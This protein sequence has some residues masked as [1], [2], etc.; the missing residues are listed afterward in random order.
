MRTTNWPDLR[1]TDPISAAEHLAA[2]QSDF[3][4]LRA[5]SSSTGRDRKVPSDL[6][7]RIY[8]SYTALNQKLVGVIS[9]QPGPQTEAGVTLTNEDTPQDVSESTALHN[10]NKPKSLTERYARPCRQTPQENIDIPLTPRSHTF[11]ITIDD[12]AVATRIDAMDN[13]QKRLLICQAT[14]RDPDEVARHSGKPWI[15]A[16]RLESGKTLRIYCHTL[17]ERSLLEMTE[18]TTQILESTLYAQVVTFGVLMEDVWIDR[19]DLR[20]GVRNHMAAQMLAIA[21]ASALPSLFKH[22]DLMSVQK[23]HSRRR[24]PANL[25]IEFATPEVANE[26]ISRGLKWGEKKHKC[27]RLVRESE[28]QKCK[29]CQRFGH[30]L[31]ECTNGVACELCLRPHPTENCIRQQCSFCR[32]LHTPG[33]LCKFHG[34]EMSKA[35]EEVRSRQPLWPVTQRSDTDVAPRPAPHR[36]LAET[37]SAPASLPRA[38]P[39]DSVQIG[40]QAKPRRNSAY[41]SNNSRVSVDDS[42]RDGLDSG[43]SAVHRELDPSSSSPVPLQ[44]QALAPALTQCKKRR[45]TR[46][47]HISNA[48]EPHSHGKRVKYTRNSTPSTTIEELEDPKETYIRESGS[49]TAEAAKDLKNALERAGIVDELPHRAQPWRRRRRSPVVEDSWYNWRPS[50]RQQLNANPGAPQQPRNPDQGGSRSMTDQRGHE[51]R[52]NHPLPYSGHHGDRYRPRYAASN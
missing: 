27:T 10:P 33:S 43:T 15:M 38:A 2:L 11:T 39:R 36:S 26:V 25:E 50:Q 4:T 21:N 52:A 20:R 12:P 32:K 16:V 23:R 3:N 18:L 31:S 5:F 9:R 1:T 13:S 44:S 48:E 51:M 35:K 47:P 46:T 49:V 8:D 22:E 17:H 14:K 45:A 19:L 30:T 6:F 37:S 42:R 29:S 24:G 40:H 34:F 28:I 7:K 41:G